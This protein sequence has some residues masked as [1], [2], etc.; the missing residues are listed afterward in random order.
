[1]HE[2]YGG[3][4]SHVDAQIGRIVDAVDELGIRDDTIIMVM[5][6][7]GASAEGGP[8]GTLNEYAFTLGSDETV[9]G[10][11]EQR[12]QLGGNRF[13]NHY[14]W[15]WAW[16]GNTPFQLWKRYTWLGGTR[17]PLVVRWPNGIADA[18]E[19]RQQ[20]THAVDI[21]PTLLEL[22]SVDTD[23]KEIDGTSIAPAFT[24]GRSEQPRTQYFEILGSR[25]IYRDGWKATTDVISGAGAERELL[26]GSRDY[27][28]DHWNL[29]DLRAD[30]SESNDLSAEQPELM[31]S[32]IA[33]WWQEAER[34]HVLPLVE[35]SFADM[36]NAAK[37]ADADTEPRT[38]YVYRPHTAPIHEDVAPSLAG[39][40]S[41]TAEFDDGGEMPEGVICA[42]GDWNNGWA[43]YV[44]NGRLHYALCRVG[45]LHVVSSRALEGPIVS[46]GMW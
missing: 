41:L 39:G 36:I 43:L 27:E 23:G 10:M 5:S 28:A 20:F 38:V 22:A 3:V 31:E 11:F 8:H 44:Q 34:N 19:V 17:T 15:S 29:F 40:F 32:M 6:D 46:L 37:E 7:N 42:Q 18:G 25:S 30:F 45:R 24:D 33:A 21:M 9:S 2:V 14:S 35:G 13:Y 1:M 16:A 4:M 26:E 12:E